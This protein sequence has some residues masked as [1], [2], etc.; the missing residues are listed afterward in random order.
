MNDTDVGPS[1]QPGQ[2]SLGEDS[3]SRCNGRADTA[4]YVA[5]LLIADIAVVTTAFVG[6]HYAGE[7][8]RILFWPAYYLHLPIAIGIGLL[9]GKI[10]RNKWILGIY[11]LSTALVAVPVLLSLLHMR[12]PSALYPLLGLLFPFGLYKTATA[13]QWLLVIAILCAPTGQGRWPL[14]AARLLA[15]CGAGLALFNLGFVKEDFGDLAA[16]FI[17]LGATPVLLL[18]PALA[19]IT[20]GG[21]IRQR[22]A[23]MQYL[24]YGLVALAWVLYAARTYPW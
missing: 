20:S 22:V 1:G 23:T 6:R 24:T 17:N 11:W 8:A 14:H 15:L 16:L 19:R 3:G 13:V 9:L 21:E 2:G 10:R 5:L 18:L 7:Y 12:Y 4:R